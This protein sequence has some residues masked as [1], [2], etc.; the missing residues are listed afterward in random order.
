MLLFFDDRDD[1]AVDEDVVRRDIDLALCVVEPGDLLALGGIDRPVGDRGEALEQAGADLAGPTAGE[2]L[3]QDHAHG[4]RI[5]ETTGDG[6]RA[7]AAGDGHLF[8]ATQAE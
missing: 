3:Q 2:D 6:L 4:L 1:L 8:V 7:V 5:V